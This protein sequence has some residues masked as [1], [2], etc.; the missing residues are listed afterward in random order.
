MGAYVTKNKFL[1]CVNIPG[2]KAHSDY[3]MVNVNGN[4]TLTYVCSII[5]VYFYFVFEI[6]SWY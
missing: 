4:S 6:I 3:Q 5:F 2:N 1:V